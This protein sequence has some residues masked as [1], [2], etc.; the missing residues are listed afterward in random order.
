MRRCLFGKGPDACAMDASTQDKNVK[1][2]FQILATTFKQ[3]GEEE[4]TA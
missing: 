1:L 4:Y 2:F 3:P